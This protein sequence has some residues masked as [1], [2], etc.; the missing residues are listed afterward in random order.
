MTRQ[1]NIKL[2]CICIL[3][4]AAMEHSLAQQKNNTAI[5]RSKIEGLLLGTF[6]GDALGGP[7]EFQEHA[8]IQASPNPPKLWT[9]TN[10]LMDDAAIKAAKERMYLRDYKYLL[11]FVQPYGCW[12]ENAPPGSV[13]D[14]SRHKMVLMQMLRT[15]W[16]KKQW[17]LTAKHSA[18]SYLDWS[19]SKIIQTHPGYDTLCPQWLGESYKSIN[20]IMGSRKIGEAYPVER[21]WNAMPTC[22]GQMALTPMAALYPGQPEKA[23]LAAYNTAWFDIGFA[24]DMVAAAVAGI[25]VALTLDPA[26][27]TNEQLWDKVF[28]AM[29][30]TDPYDYLKVPWCSR[31]VQ[32]WLDVADMYAKE[33][34]GSPAKLFAL[35]DKEF[36]YTTKWEAQVPYLVVFSI[37]KI[38]KYDPLAAMQLS[39]EWGNDHDTYP[40][41]LGAFVG[42]L[43]GPGI[44]DP[45]MKATVTKRLQLDYDVEMDEWVNTLMKVQQLG[46]TR[47]LFQN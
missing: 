13:T 30:K 32:R 36:M 34:N 15:A 14:D 38:C 16:Q 29:T 44:F 12:S 39:I 21:M 2:L 20:W 40:Q 35:L 45:A 22:Y 1:L 6:I 5:I 47:Q 8:A 28:E 10:E 27:M 37:L 9:D 46:K 3:F 26:A 42:A 19:K 18:Q 25:S 31:Q 43:Y 4:I 41:F 11:P 7:I 17:P 33:S 24:K 23:Y